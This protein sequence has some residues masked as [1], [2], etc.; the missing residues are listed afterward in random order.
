MQKTIVIFLAF[1]T[2]V[3]VNGYSQFGK[4]LNKAKEVVSGGSLSQDEAGRGLKE[5]LKLGVG[6]AVT[7][8]S[9][10]NGYLES[11]YKILLPEEAQSVVRRL[12]NVP[13]FENIEKD[14]V[15]K[16]NE[17]A[18]YAAKKATPIFTDAITT[19][20]FDDALKILSGKDDAA[21]RYLENKSYQKLYEAFM[22]VIQEA[23][24]E[25]KARDLWR[26][27]I[28]AYNKIPLVRKTNP[29]LDDHVNAKALSGLFGLI[30]H[31]E[32]GIRNNVDQRTSELLRK[33][34]GSS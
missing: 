12:K 26:S 28:T 30:E 17:A 13:G 4:V 33:V 20:S 8:L 2:F 31:K 18:E 16:M 3:N 10:T 15:N 9:A 14:L 7:Q 32:I 21:T 25:V 34:F 6:E 19:I 27:A 29:E 1:I 23:L 24:D 5:A 22:P 11:P